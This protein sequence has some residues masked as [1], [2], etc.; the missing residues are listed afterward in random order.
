MKEI[1]RTALAFAAVVTLPFVAV[2]PAAA[3]S[4]TE[5]ANLLQIIDC[6]TLEFG[7]EGFV[8]G[9][10]DGTASVVLANCDG[11]YVGDAD[12]SD[13]IS[14]D[15][16]IVTDAGDMLVDDP[17]ESVEFVGESELTILE[18][19]G[20]GPLAGIRAL[21]IFDMGDPDGVRI[22]DS[23][24]I[25][26]LNADSFTI[27][28]SDEIDNGDDVN[29]DG[30]EDCGIYAGE[31]LYG[32]QRLHVSEAGEYTFRVTGTDPVS[33]YIHAG[34]FTPWEDPMVA[35]YEGE[36]DP[37][38]PDADVAGCNDDFNDL[39][40]DGFDWSIPN[41]SEVYDRVFAVTSDN[42]AIE[43]HFPVF[44]A[45]LQPGDYTLL[46]TTYWTLT[47][48]EWSTGE[49]EYG[50][51]DPTSGSLEYEI[52]GPE[53]GIETVEEFALASTGVEP[54]LALWSGLALA[55]TGVSITVARRRARQ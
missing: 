7:G 38:N 2:A 25:V 43:G 37:A 46:I 26:P 36:F 55:G 53:G 34:T 15:D 31:H 30:D 51:W 39:T 54:S 8:I 52:W 10:W 1:A 27:G 28:T 20:D 11:Y 40:I 33:S 49:T 24:A 3:I 42:K 41:D 29:I 16:G 44:A 23:E 9:L 18:F 47:P 5:A 35:L 50:S 6:D 19:S 13:F 32:I 48:A 14:I 12:G 21:D 22:I 17:S 45:E 4:N